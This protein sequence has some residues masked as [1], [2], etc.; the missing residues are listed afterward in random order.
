MVPSTLLKFGTLNEEPSALSS[1]EICEKVLL[2]LNALA[3]AWKIASPPLGPGSKGSTPAGGCTL[4]LAA[5]GG[6][7]RR[8]FARVD[9]A[10]SKKRPKPPLT[11][12]FESFE[13]DQ[14]K[15]TLGRTFRTSELW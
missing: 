15:A 11:T 10:L 9:A 4:I 1:E 5:V 13:G 6:F 14:L 7:D 2:T 8:S 12:V 3:E